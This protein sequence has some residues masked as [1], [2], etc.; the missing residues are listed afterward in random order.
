MKEKVFFKNK[1]G[2]KLCGVLSNP[3]TCKSNHVV[4][5]C[6]GL[7]SKKDCSTGIAFEEKFNQAGL[8][9]FRFDFHAH[10]ESEGSKDNILYSMARDDIL[11]AIDFLKSRGFAKFAIIGSSFGGK[12]AMMACNVSNDI[13]VLGLRCPAVDSSDS[14]IVNFGHSTPVKWREDGKFTFPPPLGFTLDYSFYE[15]SAKFNPLDLASN[16]SVPTIIVHGK[17]DNLIP[18]DNVEQVNELISHSK[19]IVLPNSDHF[20]DYKGD[21]ETLITLISNFVVDKFIS[22]E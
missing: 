4:I 20:F 13:S 18:L 15:D 17:K 10:G 7:Y 21:F 16:I 9:Y 3:E 6:H 1:S 5:F 8:S 12:A 11:S 19:L 2:L 14:L 22:S